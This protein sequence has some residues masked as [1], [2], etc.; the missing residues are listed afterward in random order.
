[1]ASAA[2]DDEGGASPPRAEDGGASLIAVAPARLP[3]ERAADR[4]ELLGALRQQRELLEAAAIGVIDAEALE[5][6]AGGEAR[7]AGAEAAFDPASAAAPAPDLPPSLPLDAA[8]RAE[9]GRWLQRLA[10]SAREDPA[11]RA[12]AVVLLL[13]LVIA[14]GF[15]LGR[16]IGSS[17]VVTALGSAAFNIAG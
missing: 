1:M 2:R 17:G 8:A 5:D 12:A 7:G 13:A 6:A 15:E 11:V 14:G 3:R 16:A 9:A 4:A 10:R